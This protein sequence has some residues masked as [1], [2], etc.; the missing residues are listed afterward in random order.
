MFY[1]E[2]KEATFGFTTNIGQGAFGPVY[3]AQMAT[4]QTVAV[5]VLSTD[6]KQGAMEFLTEVILNYRLQ[7]VCSDKL[8]MY[9][10]LPVTENPLRLCFVLFW[11]LVHLQ[12]VNVIVPLFPGS[13]AWK[14]TP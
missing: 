7:F 9:A 12:H 4:G 1:R 11:F 14:I 10:L 3:K 13:V 8:A 2:L 5:K 6:S